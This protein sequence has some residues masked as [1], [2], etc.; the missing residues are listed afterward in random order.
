MYSIFI[1]LMEVLNAENLIKTFNMVEMNILLAKLLQIRWSKLNIGGSSRN[2]GFNFNN[3]FLL[4]GVGTSSRIQ[5]KRYINKY[6]SSLL[7]RSFYYFVLLKIV[8][9]TYPNVLC[10]AIVLK[11]WPWVTLY[12]ILILR[13]LILLPVFH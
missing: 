4:R 6:I 13:G 2:R 12:T 8:K 3:L 10:C 7:S 1:Y 9:V 11:T 5:I